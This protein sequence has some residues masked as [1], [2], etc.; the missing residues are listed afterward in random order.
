[1]LDILNIWLWSMR[2]Y[3]GNNGR[4]GVVCYCCALIYE[5]PNIRSF[6]MWGKFRI[7]GSA[8]CCNVKHL[9]SLQEPISSVLLTFDKLLPRHIFHRDGGKRLKAPRNREGFFISIGGGR[10]ERSWLFAGWL[11]LSTTAGATM[12]PSTYATCVPCSFKCVLV[13][14]YHV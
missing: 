10:E 13:G 11:S 3:L 5:L 1:M 8:I 9:N 12:Q 7:N 6:E 4:V 2:K 14:L